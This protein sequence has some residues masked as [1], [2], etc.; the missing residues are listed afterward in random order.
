M[1]FLSAAA[2]EPGELHLFTARCHTRV[3]CHSSS[4]SFALL[5][6]RLPLLPFALASALGLPLALALALAA[7]P[8]ALADRP[9]LHGNR[10]RTAGCDEVV[11]DRPPHGG[12]IGGG[13]RIEEQVCPHRG[14]GSRLHHRAPDAVAHDV[15]PGPLVLVDEPLPLYDLVEELRLVAPELE[16]QQL[17]EPRQ[18]SAHRPR[19]VPGDESPIRFVSVVPCHLSDDDEGCA[20]GEHRQLVVEA[21]RESAGVVVLVGGVQRVLHRFHNLHPFERRWA[22][23]ADVRLQLERPVVERVLVA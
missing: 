4:L 9:Y 10:R 16:A 12:P 22:L 6:R 17:G 13:R 19:V 20:I 7:F 15:R 1:S 3:A 11:L 8:A 18:A 5:S 21:G 14:R 2:A 23:V